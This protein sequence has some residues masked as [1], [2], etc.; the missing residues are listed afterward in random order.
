MS[1]SK[2]LLRDIALRLFYNLEEFDGKNALY[3][4]RKTGLQYAFLLNRLRI[5]ENMGIIKTVKL[6]K[7][8]KV[9]L[10]RRGKFFAKKLKEL[11]DFLN[12]VK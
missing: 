1:L 7:E 6:G 3:I 10:T 2:F 8:R 12:D 4:S 11:V 5:L 9:F